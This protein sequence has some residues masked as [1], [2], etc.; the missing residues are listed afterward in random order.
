MT[1]RNH[2]AFTL[3]E[4]IVVLVVIFILVALI[5]P[6]PMDGTMAKGQQTQT[7]SNMK[8][9]HLATQQMALDGVTADDTN[10]GWPGD[11]GGTFTNWTAQLL[12][13]GYLSTNDLYKLFSAPGIIVKPE[14]TTLSAT[15][16]AL[17]VYAVST[18]RPATDVFLSTANFTNTPTGGVL[19]T[20]AKPYPGKGF[21][22]FR[23]AG[24]GAILQPRQAGMTNLIGTYAPLCR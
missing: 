23:I 14:T 22:V 12:K 20:N 6:S 7:L 5:I 15:N 16:T 17:L 21:V 11:I 24:D 9:L 3:V 2:A 8:Q 1:S 10:I 4:F 19:N 13:G 18:N